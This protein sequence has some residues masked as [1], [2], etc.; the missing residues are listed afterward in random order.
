MPFT[1]DETASYIANRVLTAGG[2]SSRLFSREAVVVI[3]ERSRGI[4]RLI[5]VICDNAMLTG[6]G[7]GRRIVDRAIV[8]EVTRDFDLTGADPQVSDVVSA[9]ALPA[10]G[11]AD[12]IKPSLDA[13]EVG[14]VAPAMADAA[15]ATEM[16]PTE[17][18]PTEMLP[19][20]SAPIE[21]AMFASSTRRRF[22]FFGAR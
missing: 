20:D 14:E 15:E 8:L 22:S 19:T 1:L 6:F 9:D 3:H 2:D 5:N 18:L 13:P 10:H 16:L 12:S 21:R 7:L 4:A 11:L 17:M